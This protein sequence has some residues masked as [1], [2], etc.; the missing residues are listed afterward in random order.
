MDQ[1]IKIKEEPIWLEVKAST[2]FEADDEAALLAEGNNEDS[3]YSDTEQHANSDHDSASDVSGDEAVP[4]QP[5]E[6]APQYVG[7][8]NI[9]LWNIHPPLPNKRGKKRNIVIHPPGVTRDAQN[10]RIVS[11]SW[12]LYF[13]DSVLE[14]IVFHTNVRLRITRANYSR[15]R[16]AVDTDIAEIRALI[17]L[18]Y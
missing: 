14:K 17:G 4:G 5:V 13:P 10:A 11:E 6:P 8:N 7:R 2:S 15:E 3:E 9:T 1:E 18:F 12:A 16:D